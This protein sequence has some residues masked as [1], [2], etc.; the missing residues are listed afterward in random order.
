MVAG[1][2]LG[3]LANGAISSP[4]PPTRGPLT[5]HPDN[6][7]WFAD[8]DGR[9][10]YLVGSHTWANFQEIRRAGDRPSIT[11]PGSRIW[12]STGCSA[13]DPGPFAQ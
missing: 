5:I 7:R 9:A 12:R 8:A 11:T 4:L 13:K 6:P 3:L 2:A 1:V 10:V